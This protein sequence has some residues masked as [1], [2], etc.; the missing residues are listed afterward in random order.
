MLVWG[1]GRVCPLVLVVSACG[2]GQVPAVGDAGPP[3]AT[4]AAADATLSVMDA[5]GTDAAAGCRCDEIE[6]ADRFA[7]TARTSVHSSNYVVGCSHLSEQLQWEG[8][9]YS[10]GCSIEEGPNEHRVK[11][12][13][14]G[15]YWGNAPIGEQGE[16]EITGNSNVEPARSW[17]NDIKSWNLDPER[18]YITSVGC[19]RP[20]PGEH[21]C[22]RGFQMLHPNV[23]GSLPVGSQLSLQASC[24][25]GTLLG[26]GCALNLD[27]NYRRVNLLQSGFSA[28]DPSTWTCTWF[29]EQIPNTST[30]PAIP[31]AIGYCLDEANPP[32][33][34]QCDCCS[35]L[36]EIMVERM[37]RK[38]VS[39]SLEVGA[40]RLT[41]RCD[42]PTDTLVS[43]GCTLGGGSAGIPS[44]ITMFR[45][46]FTDITTP[47][48][49]GCSW[50]H[51]AAAGT[52]TATA[53]I[54]CL[55]RASSEQLQQ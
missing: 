11:I 37:Y 51:P 14:M 45:H 5:G 16:W 53:T 26:G 30:I 4:D 40:N 32:A 41:A 23:I 19:F 39:Q 8:L 31:V 20:D 47:D 52:T 44:G 9:A 24:P 22:D 3:L 21:S 2:S 7:Y 55:R 17:G 33:G 50:N 38:S 42:D 35:P 34:E 46:G 15:P 43:G 48:E 6:L 1:M 29:H 25:R 12:V 36:G 28:T 13:E 27:T 18:L 54:Q 10:G 49:W